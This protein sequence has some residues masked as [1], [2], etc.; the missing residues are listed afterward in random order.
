[1]DADLPPDLFGV[2]I[3]H[4]VAGSGGAETVDRS[5]IKKQSFEQARLPCSSVSKYPDIANFVAGVLLHTEKTSWIDY[6]KQV[7]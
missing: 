3:R 6:S 2:K 5:G 4:G 1:M 7:R